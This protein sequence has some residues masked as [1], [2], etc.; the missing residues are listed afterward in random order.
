S[1]GQR[2]Y[3]QHNH[4]LARDPE[5]EYL[6]GRGWNGEEIRWYEVADFG[7]SHSGDL[8][9]TLDSQTGEIRFA[10]IIR[11]RDGT[12]QMYGAIP[13][14]GMSLIMKQYRWGGGL[15]GNVSANTLVT[16]SSSLPYIARVSNR[17]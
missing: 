12:L 17:V 16:L 1:P 15:G 2:F 11:Q 6:V 7:N 8:H 3:L 9:Y 13:P 5:W 14:E 4:L 10:P